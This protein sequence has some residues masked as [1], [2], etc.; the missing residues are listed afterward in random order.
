M[1]KIVSP[2]GSVGSDEEGSG[3]RERLK[4]A[5]MQKLK[6]YQ[7]NEVNPAVVKPLKEAFLKKIRQ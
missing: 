5:F 1:I 3:A 6:K 4:Q 2:K 7:N